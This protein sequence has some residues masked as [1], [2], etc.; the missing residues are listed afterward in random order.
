MIG[1]SPTSNQVGFFFWFLSCTVASGGPVGVAEVFVQFADPVVRDGSAYMARACG[2]EMPGGLWQ[3][4]IEFVA[5]SSGEAVRS[6]RETT[7]PNREDTL[8]WATGL[9]PIYLEGALDRALNPVVRPVV[10]PIPPPIFNGPATESA[11]HSGP[12]S[13]LN[14]FSVFR[15]GETLLRR[16]LAALSPWHLV[17]IIRAHRLSDMS[18]ETLNA[19]PGPALIEMIASSVRAQSEATK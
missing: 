2:G 13:I 1:T 10:E 6:G 3:G 15:K 5:T 19:L 11:F 14:P 16:Q 9:T 4:W 12:E 18:P 7:Q 8:Y 17:N